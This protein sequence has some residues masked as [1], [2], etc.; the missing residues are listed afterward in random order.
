MT[1]RIDT[2]SGRAKL[3]PRRE[4]YWHRLAMG[5][6]IGYRKSSSDTA[7]TWIARA[8]DDATGKQNFKPL[9]TLDELD[10]DAAAKAAREWFEHLGRGGSTESVTVKGA[11][12]RYVEH[13][14][15]QKRHATADDLEARYRRWVNDSKLGAV[16]LGKLTRAH[17]DDWRKS[18]TSAV[19]RVNH[20]DHNPVTRERSPSSVNRD[21]TALRAALNHA[22]DVG[23]IATDMPWRVALRPTAGAD[24]RRDI[25]LD[26][27]QRKKLI[28][29]CAADIGM[30]VRAM[31]LLPLRPGALAALTVADFDKRLSTLRIGKDKTGKERRI[32]LPAATAA[33]IAQQAKDKTPAAHLFTRADGKAWDKDAWKKPLKAAALA[34]KLPAATTAYALRHSTI[35]DLVTAGLPI[36]T[37]AQLSGTS[38]AMIERHYGHL[39]SDRA[40]AALAGLVL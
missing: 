35:T 24:R 31:C 10:F 7:G 13:V 23:L 2:V 3:K 9:G 8:Y 33:L 20:D 17:I 15:S 21:A 1:A 16:E 37:V 12:A 25:Y 6:Y 28:E 39:Q 40:A 18:L 22:H 36:L 14:R 32:K 29:N 4:P 27:D 11:C 26:R 30:F 38:V 5:N 34:A 19:V